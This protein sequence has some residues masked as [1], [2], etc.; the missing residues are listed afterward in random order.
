MISRYTRSVIIDMKQRYSV[1]IGNNFSFKG[2]VSFSVQSTWKS[3]HG[4]GNSKIEDV[5][6]WFDEIQFEG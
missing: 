6:C 3:Y 4:R 1:V 5:I 2:E